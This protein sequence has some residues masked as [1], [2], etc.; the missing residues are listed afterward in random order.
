[1][2]GTLR[3]L[4][5]RKCLMKIRGRVSWVFAEFSINICIDMKCRLALSAWLDVIR[6]IILKNHRAFQYHEFAEWNVVMCIKCCRV[7]ESYWVDHFIRVSTHDFLQWHF[8][9]MMKYN[10]VDIEF[11]SKSN[12]GTVVT[13]VGAFRDWVSYN[14]CSCLVINFTSGSVALW[15]KLYL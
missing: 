3:W 15:V 1:M 14:I 11:S 10:C 6:F 12:D 13:V 4:M 8:K 9:K 7:L 2:I 5:S